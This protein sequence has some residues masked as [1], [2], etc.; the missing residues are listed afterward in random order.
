MRPANASIEVDEHRLVAG[1]AH[2]AQQVAR[3]AGVTVASFCSGWQFTQLVG[4]ELG[5][6]HVGDPPV[7]DR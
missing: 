4:E 7:R 1:A 6:E 3:C 2:E 5:V